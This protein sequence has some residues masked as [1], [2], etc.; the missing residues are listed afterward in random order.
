ML[1]QKEVAFV[2]RVCQADYC[3]D[4]LQQDPDDEVQPGA[5]D[6]GAGRRTTMMTA[7]APNSRPDSTTHGVTGGPAGPGRVPAWAGVAYLAAWVAG[8]AAWPANLALNATGAQVAAAHRAH[9]AGATTQYLLVEGLAGLL[10][11]VVMAFWLLG[12]RRAAGVAGRRTAIGLSVVAVVTSLTQCG[13][14]LGVI[15]A[16]TRHQVGSS[17]D[18]F[19]L[20]NRLD[21]V[22]MLALAGVAACFVA[23]R[24]P[25]ARPPRWLTVTAVALA[26][27]LVTSGLAYLV[28]ANPLAWTAFVSGPLLLIWVTGTGIWLTRTRTA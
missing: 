19:A 16:A 20:V 13:L 28:L 4:E 27:A 5:G 24:S 26:V 11:G 25:A 14:G 9:V 15:A 12:G 6:P 7:P 3:N 23:T 18:L 17:G 21:G 8:L 10:L 2:E 1:T 22:K